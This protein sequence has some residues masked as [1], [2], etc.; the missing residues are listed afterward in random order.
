MHR[1]TGVLAYG[2]RRQLEI[3]IALACDP[4]VLLL[5]E[6]GAGVS[7]HEREMIVKIICELPQVVSIL[8]IEH[9]MRMIFSFAERITV[10]TDGAILMEGDPSQVARD[11]AVKAAYLG[12]DKAVAGDVQSAGL[13]LLK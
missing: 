7:L 11:P 4:Q 5:D 12:K 13:S 9:D 1:P 3:G 10:M 2:Q 6:P 8:L